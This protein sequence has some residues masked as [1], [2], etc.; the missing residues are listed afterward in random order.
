MKVLIKYYILFQIAGKKA[1]IGGSQVH[2][3]GDIGLV[4]L[5][6]A[7]VE[8]LG[9]LRIPAPVAG[10]VADELEISH[11]EG[12]H[13]GAV[14]SPVNLK[15]LRLDGNHVTFKIQFFNLSHLHCV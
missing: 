14:F 9:Y 15:L 12:A 1:H 6:C 5:V 7:E 2:Q 8:D 11:V 10:V 13:F 4:C 3:S